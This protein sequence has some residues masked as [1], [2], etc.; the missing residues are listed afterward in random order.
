MTTERIEVLE[1]L[2]RVVRTEK[3]RKMGVATDARP[4]VRHFSS[5]AAGGIG[6][7]LGR[8]STGVQYSA[9]RPWGGAR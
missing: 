8:T 3:E 4:A 1:V 7:N 2:V 5:S 9:C 6:D